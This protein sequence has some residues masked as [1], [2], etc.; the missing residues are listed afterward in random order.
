MVGLL[1]AL[2]RGLAPPSAVAASLDP[3]TLFAVP[4][5][6]AHG[7]VLA[8]VSYRDVSERGVVGLSNIN[9]RSEG[10]ARCSE[11]APAEA[12]LELHD[13]ALLRAA[14]EWDKEGGGWGWVRAGFA[15]FYVSHNYAVP[16]AGH[17]RA[18]AYHRSYFRALDAVR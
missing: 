9:R 17:R 13:A 16:D 1:V 10:G 18:R 15:L 12:L 4:A 6:P 5:A 3:T 2:S 7:L 11:A 8:G 14:R